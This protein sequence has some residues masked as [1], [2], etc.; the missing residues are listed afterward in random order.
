MLSHSLTLFGRESRGAIMMIAHV[1]C[2][3]SRPRVTLPLTHPNSLTHSF[4]N[5]LFSGYIIFTQR[6]AHAFTHKSETLDP[7]P[8]PSVGVICVTPSL[9]PESVTHLHSSHTA[10][11]WHMAAGT[12]SGAFK[13]I[14]LSSMEYF[15]LGVT[16]SKHIHV[17]TC[18]V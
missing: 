6:H 1:S 4:F 3:R 17:D 11:H 18:C 13:G 12:L 16:G 5:A 14:R 9:T 10:P 8:C 15:N 7:S 2:S